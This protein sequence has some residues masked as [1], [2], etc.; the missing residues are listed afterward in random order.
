LKDFI[1][2]S[3]EQKQKSGRNT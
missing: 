1:F 2:I 3:E